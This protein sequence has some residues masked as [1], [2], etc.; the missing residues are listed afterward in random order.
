MKELFTKIRE[1]ITRKRV[2]WFFIVLTFFILFCNKHIETAT[3]PYLYNNINIL[4]KT[5]VALLLGTSNKRRSGEEN[6]YFTNRIKAAYDLYY[7]GKVKKFVLSGDNINNN[8]NEPRMM[9]KALMELGV[10]DSVMTLDYAGIRTFDSMI[11]AKEIFGLDTVMVISQRFH[12]ERAVFIGRKNGMIAYG[13]NASNV[14]YEDQFKMKL[15][16]LFAKVKCFLDVYI[17]DTRPKHLGE[18]IKV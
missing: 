13:Y 5:R 18:K 15:R 3:E 7:Y 10:P 4:P 16:E 8:Y 12:N 2:M 6:M 17:L 11:R 1:K 9:R 14:V